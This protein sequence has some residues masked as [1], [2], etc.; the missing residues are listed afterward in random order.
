M[1][2][3]KIEHDFDNGIKVVNQSRYDRTSFIAFNTSAR[4]DTTP[5]AAIR[6]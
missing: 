2:T 6:A 1:P 3:L 4:F 5:A